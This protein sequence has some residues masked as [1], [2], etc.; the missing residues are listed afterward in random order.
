MIYPKKKISSIF[1]NFINTIL[2]DKNAIQIKF[3]KYM[4]YDLDLKNPVTFNEKLQWLKLYHRKSEHTIT[5]DKYLMRKYV[6]EIIGSDYLI[7]LEFQTENPEELLPESI[8]DYPVIIKVNHDCAGSKIIYNKTE[9]DWVKL[10]SFFSKKLKKKY[11]FYGREY[12]Y[13]DIKPRLIV[14][15]LLL[16]KHDNIP[17]DYKVYCFNGKAKMFAVDKDRGKPS[18]ARNWYDLNWDKKE[19]YWNTPSDDSDIP[20]PLLLDKI[21]ELS[22][23]IANDFIFIRVD[24]YILNTELYIGELTLHPGSGLVKFEPQKWDKILGDYIKLP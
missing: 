12:Q 7:P 1:K 10:R 4:G 14:E 5:A 24:W 17:Y 23:K 19:I 11:Y 8:P 22:E 21:I 13:R 2:S 6:S 3:K 20:K 18:K 15:K 9:A 16:D